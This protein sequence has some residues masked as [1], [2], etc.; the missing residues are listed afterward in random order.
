MFSESS[1]KGSHTLLI[2][3]EQNNSR[4]TGLNSN[5]TLFL[6]V[7]FADHFES[8]PLWCAGASSP[9]T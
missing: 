1:T 3:D 9:T 7:T 5:K 8:S 6:E 4:P 2:N